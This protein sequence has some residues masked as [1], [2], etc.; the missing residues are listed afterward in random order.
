MLLQM[1][2]TLPPLL[3]DFYKEE[4]LELPCHELIMKCEEM[5]HHT[6]ST[7]SGKGRQIW[8]VDVSLVVSTRHVELD[9]HF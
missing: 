2:G 8:K 4:Y 9:E 6:C 7:R 5:Q 3:S 1:T